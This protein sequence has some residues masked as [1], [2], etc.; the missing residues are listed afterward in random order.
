MQFYGQLL[1]FLS[2]S[3]EATIGFPQLI[4]NQVSRSVDG[5]SVFMIAT[6]FFGDLFKTLY[7]IS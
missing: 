1:G 7:F 2:L 3:I 6:W 4:T 5:L